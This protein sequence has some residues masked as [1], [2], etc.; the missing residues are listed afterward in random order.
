MEEEPGS[1]NPKSLIGRLDQRLKEWGKGLRTK[2]RSTDPESNTSEG[3]SLAELEAKGGIPPER[4][5][6]FQNI[7]K[8]N[9]P[10]NGEKAESPQ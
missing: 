6:L 10:N 2:I 8:P 4:N 7:P 5:R 1:Q 3:F 9:N